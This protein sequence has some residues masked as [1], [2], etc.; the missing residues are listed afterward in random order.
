M[1]TESMNANTSTRQASPRLAGYAIAIASV[2]SVAL[3]A[4]HPSVHHHDIASALDEIVRMSWTARV[5]HGALIASMLV[6]SCALLEL[7]AWLGLHRISV[8]A[9]I[10]SYMIGTIAM[11][12]AAL[13]SGFLTPALASSYV[14]PASDQELARQ[15]LA[16]SAIGNHT[17]AKFAVVVMS[18]AIFSWSIALLQPPRRVRWVAAIGALVSVSSAIPLCLGVLQLDVT[19]MTVVFIGQS[20]WNLAVAFSLIRA[21]RSTSA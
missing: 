14:A 1:I 9:A 11:I 13:I 12:G 16:L 6:V 18:F 7:S 19:G 4:H 8:R 5:V 3:M 2:L 17:L 20:V 10:V 21:A 15:L